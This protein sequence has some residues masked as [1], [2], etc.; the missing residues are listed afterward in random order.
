MT[1]ADLRDIKCDN[2][3]VINANFS[4][5]V[6]CN[7]EWF[8][9]Q[10]HNVDLT[11]TKLF[12]VNSSKTELHNVNLTGTKIEHNNHCGIVLTNLKLDNAVLYEVVL[13]VAKIENMKITSTNF[14]GVIIN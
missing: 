13:T 8:R 6:V 3:R 5:A 14:N 1:G 12:H 11:D 7:V 2:I 4:N 9:V 10:L